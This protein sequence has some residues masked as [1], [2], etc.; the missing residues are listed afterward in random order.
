[1]HL[2]PVRAAPQTRCELCFPAALFSTGT[3]SWGPPELSAR[4]DISATPTTWR[5]YGL[6]VRAVVDQIVPTNLVLLGVCTP[7]E[8]SD[9]PPGKWLLLDCSDDECRARLAPREDTRQIKDALEDA[10]NYR[11]LGLP[12]LDGTSVTPRQVAREPNRVK[13]LLE[14]PERVRTCLARDRLADAAERRP[15]GRLPSSIGLRLR[16]L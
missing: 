1:M 5:T 7:D 15:A 14:S 13:Q 9:W 12:T 2:I 16:I 3:V 8:L 6:L 11:G 4:A 10:A